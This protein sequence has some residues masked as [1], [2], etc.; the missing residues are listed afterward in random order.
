[1]FD[2][3]FCMYESFGYFEDASNV[4]VLKGIARALKPGGKLLLQVTNRDFVVNEMPVRG[5]WEGIGCML[6][7]EV[8]FNFFKS[9]LVTRRSVVF[10]DGRQGMQKSAVRLY[11]LHELGRALGDAG[12]KVLEVSGSIDHRGVFLGASS[13][14][15]LLL[16]DKRADASERERNVFRELDRT[17]VPPAPRP[18][19]P[20]SGSR[21]GAAAAPPLPPVPKDAKRGEHA[22][23]EDD[24]EA[25][26][27]VRT[28]PLPRFAQPDDDEGEELDGPSLT[29]VPEDDDDADG[30]GETQPF[31]RKR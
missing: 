11:S 7:E 18:A 2:A 24:D 9:V 6:L 17:P 20:S 30:S 22:S 14:E 31:R 28:A 26:P 8:D 1:M 5:W 4:K 12:F 29:P 16:C 10:E 19:G 23:I 25:T 27:T 3:C 21:G 13:R 15:I